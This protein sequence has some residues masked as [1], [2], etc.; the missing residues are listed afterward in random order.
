M[1]RRMRLSESYPSRQKRVKRG[2]GG[3]SHITRFSR[4]EVDV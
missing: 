2:K 1:E 4:E 3:F